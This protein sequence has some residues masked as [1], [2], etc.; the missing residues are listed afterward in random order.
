MNHRSFTT[1]HAQHMIEDAA[2]E[3]IKAIYRFRRAENDMSDD[4]KEARCEM[5]RLEGVLLWTRYCIYSNS[6][7]LLFNMPKTTRLFNRCPAPSWH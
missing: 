5:N 4:Y 1:L 6:R 2:Q 3:Y 7:H